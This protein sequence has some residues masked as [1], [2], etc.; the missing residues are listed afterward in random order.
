MFKPDKILLIFLSN[1][2]FSIPFTISSVE[3]FQKPP[4]EICLRNE[5][6]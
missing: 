5:E 3:I 6:L 1:M 4:P 2:K